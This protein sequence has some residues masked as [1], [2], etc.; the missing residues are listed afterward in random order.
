MIEV[1]YAAHPMIWWVS[2]EVN[3]NLNGKPNSRNIHI[4]DSIFEIQYS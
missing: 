1:N 3:H 4:A 2:G